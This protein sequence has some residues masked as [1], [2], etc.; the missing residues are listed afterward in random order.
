MPPELAPLSLSS[1]VWVVTG[2]NIRIDKLEVLAGRVLG[3]GCVMSDSYDPDLHLDRPAGWKWRAGLVLVRRRPRRV[4]APDP[5]H[6]GPQPEPTQLRRPRSPPRSAAWLPRM[7]PVLGNCAPV[8]S[9]R[10]RALA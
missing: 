2:P 9:E 4:Y 10:H 1:T 3:T 7:R 6:Q 8:A 5:G